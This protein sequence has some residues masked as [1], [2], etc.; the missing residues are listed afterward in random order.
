MQKVLPENKVKVFSKI[1]QTPTLC[2]KSDFV[3]QN[4][5]MRIIDRKKEK[6]KFR[7]INNQI[8]N[9]NQLTTQFDEFFIDLTQKLN[10]SKQET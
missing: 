5:N 8:Q 7:S 10:I 6:M 3:F 1:G 9:K 4:T 2:S